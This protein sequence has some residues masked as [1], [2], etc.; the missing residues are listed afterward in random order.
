M[1][2]EQSAEDELAVLAFEGLD[3]RD[4]IDVGP[5]YWEAKHREL[6]ERLRA[7]SGQ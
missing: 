6:D 5:E 3:S 2:T 1:S 7:A 4:P